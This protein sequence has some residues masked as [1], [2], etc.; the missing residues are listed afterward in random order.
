MAS[1]VLG[2]TKALNGP[3][4]LLFA[5]TALYPVVDGLMTSIVGRKNKDWLDSHGFFWASDGTFFFNKKEMEEYQ[6]KLDAGEKPGNITHAQSPTVWQQGMLDT[7]ASLATG[8]GAASGASWLQGMRATQE[9]L[10]NAMQN[11][12]RPTKAGEALLGWLQPKLSQLEAKYNLPTG[13]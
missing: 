8:R 9:K 13:L 6:A 10:G 3:G 7:Q 11:R 5:I 2:L 12:P 1:W 4:G